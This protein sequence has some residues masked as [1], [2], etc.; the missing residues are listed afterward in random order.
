MVSSKGNNQEATME[1][2]PRLRI[3]VLLALIV[4]ALVSSLGALLWGNQE[5]DGLALNFGTEMA[6]A[7]VTY[8]LLELVIGRME[9]REAEREAEMKEREARKAD[10][11]AQMGST[12]KDVAVAAVEELQR[13]GWLTDGSLR[14]AYLRMANLEGANL[15]R[16]DLQEADLVMANLQDAN[17]GNANLQKTGL[18]GA[19]VQKA[20]LNAAN[21]RE[22]RLQR[23]NVREA[24]L[25]MA[26][27]YGASLEEANLSMANLYGANL[28]EANL[29][30]ANLEGAHFSEGKRL[31]DGTSWRPETDMARFTDPDHPDFWRPDAQ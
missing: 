4:V 16:A 25:S 19:N 22:A 27:L 21:L 24:N 2:T 12:V 15:F 10:L 8:L 20:I 14:G 1:R 17:L 13:Y 7:V 11:I 29:K 3:A 9:R 30:G 28:E 26:N 6:G 31:P 23:A 18:S 5:L